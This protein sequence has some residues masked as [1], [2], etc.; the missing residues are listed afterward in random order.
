MDG[1]SKRQVNRAGD[2]LR[3]FFETSEPV[4]DDVVD[5]LVVLIRFREL[6]QEPLNKV[7]MGVRS[8]VCTE[9]G[10]PRTGARVP[11]SQR[12]KR[13]E[14]IVLKLRRYPR[15]QFARMQ[16][17]GGCRAVL[18]SPQMVEAVYGRMRRNKWDIRHL[19]DHRDNP[20]PSGYRALHVVVERQGRLIEIQLRTPRQHEWALAVERTGM[21][22]GIRLKE[23]E[24]PADLRQY[25]RLAAEGLYREEMG[26]P[27]EPEFMRHFTAARLAVA[28][29]F[30]T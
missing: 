26:F 3:A 8:M 19:Q 6:F 22:L 7:A 16:D 1:L 14:Q 9:M 11:V 30:K 23:D 10:L 12:L 29:Y 13:R 25:F 20:A 24:G 4:T 27:E 28:D 17:V 21:R 5:A 2:R 18:A 15:M